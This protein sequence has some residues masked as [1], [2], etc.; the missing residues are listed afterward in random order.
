MSPVVKKSKKKDEGYFLRSC[1]PS[2]QNDI[3]CNTTHP[4]YYNP[5]IF[6][7]TRWNSSVRRN[8]RGILKE[9]LRF[10]LGRIMYHNRE[11]D[12]FLNCYFSDATKSS[13]MVTVM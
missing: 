5:Y 12:I 3:L 7:Y 1:I 11:G 2:S 6:C 13:H 8:L 10:I 4:H 9:N